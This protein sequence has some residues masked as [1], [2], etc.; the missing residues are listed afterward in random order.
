MKQREMVIE[1]IALRYRQ[2][3]KRLANFFHTLLKN[4]RLQALPQISAN[5]KSMLDEL[6]KLLALEITSAFP[7]S[8][9]ERGEIQEK[10]QRDYGSLATISWKTDPE[11]LGGLIIK[12]GDRLLDASV[13]G[14]L[15]HMRA[16][17][18]A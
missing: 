7:L 11:I 18:L 1:S 6:K 4:G 15:E 8:D 5:F 12:Y 9:S 10:I 17:L 16:A 2:D 14:S 13:S 3:D